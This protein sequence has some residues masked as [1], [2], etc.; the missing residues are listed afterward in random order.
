VFNYVM[1]DS[2]RLIGRTSS[3]FSLD[4]AF[5]NRLVNGILDD[6]PNIFEARLQ[7]YF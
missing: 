1:V 3:T 7:F 2:S 4:P 6:S 5:N